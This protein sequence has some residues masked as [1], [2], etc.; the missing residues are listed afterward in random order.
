MEFPRGGGI[1]WLKFPA[2]WRQGCCVTDSQVPEAPCTFLE[3]QLILEQIEFQEAWIKF[4]AFAYLFK[5]IVY[6]W[7]P[8][9]VYF[10]SPKGSQKIFLGSSLGW[11][12]PFE[13][14]FPVGHTTYYVVKLQLAKFLMSQC[15]E[16]LQ[17]FCSDNVI[18]WKSTI[19][20]GLFNSRSHNLS[21]GKT[22][23]A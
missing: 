4:R 1:K 23:Q 12:C 22:W 11:G 18:M 19:I 6:P 16:G 7:A 17:A 10:R 2:R 13:I 21:H 20:V 5:F 8:R 3:I 15:Q 14:I 9:K